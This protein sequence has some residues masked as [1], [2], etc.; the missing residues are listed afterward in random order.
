MTVLSIIVL[1]CNVLSAEHE[2]L[3]GKERKNLPTDVFHITL[4]VFRSQMIL[5]IG[6]SGHV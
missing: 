2:V 5:I 6:D 3:A 4:L 1:S